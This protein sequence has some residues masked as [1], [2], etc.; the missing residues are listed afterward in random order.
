MSSKNGKM[1][2]KEKKKTTDCIKKMVWKDMCIIPNGQKGALPV[3]GKR[4]L[5][6]STS[7]FQ[8]WKLKL[9]CKWHKL[10]F[11]SQP[12]GAGS[13]GE[14]LPHK[15]T[16]RTLFKALKMF[17]RACSHSRRVIYQRFVTFQGV[18]RQRKRW[19][20]AFLCYLPDC[21]RNWTE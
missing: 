14:S 13:N 12:L 18:P 17:W 8:D 10:Q 3:V 9:M 6:V 2:K 11:L 7:N 15:S 16:L 5:V 20:S 19:P 4:S 21:G 1:K